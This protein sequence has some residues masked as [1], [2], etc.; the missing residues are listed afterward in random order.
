MFESLLGLLLCRK[1]TI[2]KRF[3]EPTSQLHS[4]QK[5]L[6]SETYFQFRHFC[7]PWAGC[8]G[9]SSTD[10]TKTQRSIGEGVTTTS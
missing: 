7:S 5:N 9:E 3:S 4:L 10:E 1:V 6:V 2:V 8:H